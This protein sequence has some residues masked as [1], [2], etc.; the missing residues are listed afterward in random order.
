MLLT[1]SLQLYR[2]RGH[3]GMI[4]DCL[5]GLA[6]VYQAKARMA[7]DALRI[8]RLYGAAHCGYLTSPG[9][10]RQRERFGYTHELAAIRSK[11]DE[12]TFAAAWAE[13]REMTLE[14]AIAY[15]LGGSNLGAESSAGASA[16]DETD[17]G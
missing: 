14:E 2:D 16:R 1:K 8:V 6:G 17:G 5:A 3:R 11:L 7:A 10:L 12:M 15:A 13:G 4:A 9:L